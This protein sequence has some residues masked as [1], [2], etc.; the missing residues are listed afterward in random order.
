MTMTERQCHKLRL[1]E[2]HCYLCPFVART[3]LRQNPVT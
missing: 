2:L 3:F 1:V